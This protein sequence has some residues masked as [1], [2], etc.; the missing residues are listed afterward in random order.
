MVQTV[1]GALSSEHHHFPLLS[2]VIDMTTASQHRQRPSD[3]PTPTPHWVFDRF[4]DLIVGPDKKLS[5]L[6]LSANVDRKLA[7]AN[8]VVDRK[9]AARPEYHTT[10]ECDRALETLFVYASL[11]GHP[12]QANLHL[13]GHSRSNEKGFIEAAVAAVESL[14][15]T[16]TCGTFREALDA[17]KAID[18]PLAVTPLDTLS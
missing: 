13:Q 10:E 11:G 8:A 14:R 1:R 12:K 6:H 18:H 4:L 7:I 5:M 2:Q 17:S 9:L 3:T 16:L 15:G